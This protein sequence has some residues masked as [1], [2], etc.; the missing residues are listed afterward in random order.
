MT[1]A[2]NITDSF[3]NRFVLQDNSGQVLVDTGPYRFAR[4]T[5]TVGES[6]T[7]FV[8]GMDVEAC[9]IVRPDGSKGVMRAARGPPPWAGG[10]G[11]R[12]SR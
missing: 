4:L 6:L 2:G 3:G 10:R 12:G 9:E 5:F 8:H 7:S 11:R 1:I